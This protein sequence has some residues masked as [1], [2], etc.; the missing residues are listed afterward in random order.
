MPIIQLHDS[1]DNSTMLATVSGCLY[2]FIMYYKYEWNAVLK[3]IL[4]LYLEFFGRWSQ[5]YCPSSSQLHLFKKLSYY[6]WQ[7][8]LSGI[9]HSC[10]GIDGFVC[11]SCHARLWSSWTYQCFSS[12]HKC[13]S[14]K[15]LFMHKI[16][17]FF[18]KSVYC[19]F[20]FFWFFVFYIPKISC[21]GFKYLRLS[22]RNGEIDV[23]YTCAIFLF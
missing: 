19:F 18:L 23:Y 21:L 13:T 20:G 7:L 6:W 14:G 5:W 10:S 1:K 4:V 3:N 15:N 11:S 16:T 12:G 8:W 17:C 2:T 22:L 9:K